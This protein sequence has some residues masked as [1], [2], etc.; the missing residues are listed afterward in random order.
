MNIKTIYI[1]D[2]DGFFSG[3]S[4]AQISPKSGTLIMPE[5]ATEIAP[6]YQDGYFA[7]WDGEKWESIAKP[8]TAEDCAKIGAIS[9]K[10]Q[11]AHDIELRAIFQAIAQNSETHELHFDG[12]FLS[13]VKKH[14]PPKPTEAEKKQNRIAELKRML[15][16]TDYIVLKIAEGS[17]TKKEYSEKI[18]QRQAWR[19]EI[20][21]L[22]SEDNIEE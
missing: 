9:H 7:K 11:A 5:N 12:D 2:S 16:E 8:V 13:I 10:S 19:T 14:E 18:A 20:N 1:F 4:C 3:V 15:T 22:E 6:E 17:A 21:D